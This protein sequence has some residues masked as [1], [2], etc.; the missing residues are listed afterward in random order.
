MA[1]SSGGGCSVSRAPPWHPP[2]P[3]K[4]LFLFWGGESAPPGFGQRRKQ[5]ST[6][7]S[8]PPRFPAK[9]RGGEAP[10]EEFGFLHTTHASGILRLPALAGWLPAARWPPR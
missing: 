6:E 3:C 1:R 10:G 2:D 4:G 7:A 8:P 9:L 5:L